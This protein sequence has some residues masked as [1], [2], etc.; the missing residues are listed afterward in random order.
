MKNNMGKLNQILNEYAWDNS[1]KNHSITECSNILPPTY[2][3]RI[4]NAEVDSDNAESAIA[5]CI[6]KHQIGEQ[7]YGCLIKQ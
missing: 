7:N 5:M 3:V 4:G 6:V 2:R 1:V